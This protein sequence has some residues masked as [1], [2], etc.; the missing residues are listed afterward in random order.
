MVLKGRTLGKRERKRFFELLD[1][2]RQRHGQI[3]KNA[4]SF[5][6]GPCDDAYQNDLPRDT[7]EAIATSFSKP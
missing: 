4:A 5:P 6:D 3:L 7:M 2:I 1:E